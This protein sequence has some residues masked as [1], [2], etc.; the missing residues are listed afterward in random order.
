[1]SAEDQQSRALAFLRLSIGL[2]F[3]IFAEYKLT[4]TRFI[5]G[6][7]A[8]YIRQFIDQGS[9]P[10]LRPFLKEIILPHA[11]FFGA[12]VSVSECL[13]AVSFLSGALVR[14]ASAGGLT[15]MLLFLFSSNYPGPHAPLWEF[16]G[17]SLDHSVLAL[18]FI[19]LLLSPSNQRWTLLRLRK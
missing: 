8:Q 14:W 10:F 9:Y 15:M 7:M 16:F 12:I 2:L 17:A 13:I 5:W 1:M 4:S 19:T 18:C 11:V 3:F 6:G